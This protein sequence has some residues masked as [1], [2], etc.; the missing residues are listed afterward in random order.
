MID[1][2][3]NSY[4]AASVSCAQ[5]EAELDNL[6]RKSSPLATL[7]EDAEFAEIIKVASDCRYRLDGRILAIDSICPSL[8]ETYTD[9]ALDMMMQFMNW[10]IPL[11]KPVYY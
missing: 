6:I 3:N 2:V 8:K 9:I 11:Q 7:M 5:K 1:S 4:T 10:E